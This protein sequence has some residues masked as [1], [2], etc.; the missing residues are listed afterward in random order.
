MWMS[1]ETYYEKYLGD[2]CSNNCEKCFGD[3]EIYICKKDFTV[4]GKTIL[5]RIKIEEGEWFWIHSN[6]KDR[7]VLANGSKHFLHLS[8]KTFEKY[9]EG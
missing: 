6:T 4:S 5:D 3:K 8:R 9:F 2:W 1:C 7:V